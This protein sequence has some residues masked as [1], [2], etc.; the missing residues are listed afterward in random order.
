MH[1]GVRGTRKARLDENVRVVV[2]ERESVQDSIQGAP[3]TPE[4]PSQALFVMVGTSH[5]GNVGAAARA[6]KTMG[7]SGLGLVAP[8][9][10]DVRSRPEAVAMASGAEDVLRGARQG[11]TLAEVAGDCGLLVALSAR[12]RDFGPP[13]HGPEWL[14]ELARTS[15]LQQRRVAFVFGSERY[16]LDNETVWRCDALLNLPT[17]P[18]YGSLNLAQAVQLVAWEWR[19]AVGAFAHAGPG[20]AVEPAATHTE[21]EGLLEHVRQTLLVLG[22]LDPQAPRRLMPRLSRLA[23]RAALTRQ[24]VQIL[25]GICHAAL[26]RAAG[27]RESGD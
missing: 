16:G 10:D 14:A 15:R 7:F 22:Y 20:P 1:G 24:E 18:D 21:V 17:S 13:L 3:G 2:K 25:R 27:A 4:L 26:Q 23:S 11:G 9:F 8:R 19:K 5:A 6:I 12:V